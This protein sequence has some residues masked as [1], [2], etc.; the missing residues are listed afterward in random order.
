MRRCG[1]QL[2]KLM[3]RLSVKMRQYNCVGRSISYLA[4]LIVLS[5]YSTA[6]GAADPFPMTNILP[7]ELAPRTLPWP[8]TRCEY[9][10]LGVEDGQTLF[11]LKLRMAKVEWGPR[12]CGVKLIRSITNYCSE[13]TK[14]GSICRIVSK[15]VRFGYC[16][17][18]FA[19][20]VPSC[21]EEAVKCLGTSAGRNLDEFKC[22]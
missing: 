15:E 22:V 13:T 18:E 10:P 11:T 5:F 14:L 4:V 20:A 19:V 9:Y 17:L 2:V 6:L 1:L 7:A 16:F 8:M 3:R 21:V 12:I